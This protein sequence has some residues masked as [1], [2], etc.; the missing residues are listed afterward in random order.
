MLAL[1]GTRVDKHWELAVE[2][3]AIELYF[4]AGT[5]DP[6]PAKWP[7]RGFSILAHTFCWSAQAR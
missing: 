5:R 6:H 4:P 7:W 2:E 1:L 3:V